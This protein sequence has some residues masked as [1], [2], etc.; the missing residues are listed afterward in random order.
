[1]C[2]CVCVWERERERERERCRWLNLLAWVSVGGLIIITLLTPWRLNSVMVYQVSCGVHVGRS[3]SHPVSVLS[4]TRSIFGDLFIIMFL[5]PVCSPI[6]S[7]LR[8]SEFDDHV[9]IFL[10]IRLLNFLENLMKFWSYNFHIDL[11][12]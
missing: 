12:V 8:Y 7:L 10:C 11:C 4:R 1:M 6:I 5:N 2:V 3:H 9:L